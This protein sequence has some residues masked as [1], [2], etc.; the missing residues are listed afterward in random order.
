MSSTPISSSQTTNPFTS[1]STSSGSDSTSALAAA[2]QSTNFNSFLTL[3]TAQL[4]NQDP[5]NPQDSTQFVEQL[6]TFSSVEQQVESNT[7]L[8]SIQT[9]LNRTNL[10]DASSWIGR[11]V[12]APTSTIAYAGEPVD[13][14][15]PQGS[16]GVS[17]DV[18]VRD[19]NGSEVLR[20]TVGENQQAITFDGR[21]AN[22]LTLPQGQYSVDVES[23]GSDGKVTAT[24]LFV[25][26]AVREAQISNGS[27]ELILDNGATVSPS[28]VQAIR[29]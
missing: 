5:L 28:D 9:S 22:G 16:S 8:R 19:R 21:D 12:V 24:P 13:L 11:E 1:Q 2:T 18:V 17:R 6:A 7:L 25:S 10:N 15:V 3:L 4:R 20:S 26:S 14:V 27:I 23:V 29:G